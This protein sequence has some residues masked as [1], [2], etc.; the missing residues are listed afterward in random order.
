MNELKKQISKTIQEL[1]K[2]IKNNGDKAIV[3]QKRQELDQMLKE[4]LKQI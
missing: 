3:N 2:L 1:E 4:Y